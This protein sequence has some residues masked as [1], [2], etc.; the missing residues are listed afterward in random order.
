MNV[1]TSEPDALLMTTRSK[2][3]L[4][5]YATRC[6]KEALEKRIS[7]PKKASG[8]ASA[9]PWQSWRESIKQAADEN[10]DPNSKG[11]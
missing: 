4:L 11:G 5:N 1:H 10:G 7:K 8:K 9:S 3:V 2:G 6:K